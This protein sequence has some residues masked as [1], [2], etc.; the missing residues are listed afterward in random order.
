MNRISRWLLLSG[1]LLVLAGIVFGAGFGIAVDHEPRL[2]AFDDYG[3]VFSRLG[4]AEATRQEIDAAIDR[5]SVAHRRF[6]GVHTH[7]VNV[8]ILL[9]LLGIVSPVL[10]S[11]GAPRPR[12][13][14]VLAVA[15]WIYPAGLL[16]QFLG[17]R[18]AGEIVAATGAV[19]IIAAFSLFFLKMVRALDALQFSE[20][21]RTP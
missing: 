15:A 7:S 4:E 5:R 2:A 6:A 18:L 3:E 16:L 17:L 11:A 12:G 21:E 19:A 9:L 20:D 10:G 1:L 13:I 14:V 8:G